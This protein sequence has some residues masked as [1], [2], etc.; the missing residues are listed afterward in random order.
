MAVHQSA[1][2]L[3]DALSRGDML[4]ANKNPRMGMRGNS[5]QG[6][7]GQRRSRPMTAKVSNNQ[8]F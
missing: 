3:N 6:G 5:A 2:D 1:V 4:S 8:R 7:V